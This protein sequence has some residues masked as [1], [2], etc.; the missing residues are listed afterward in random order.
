MYA[1]IIQDK[2][3]GKEEVSRYF[4]TKRA[5]KSWLRWLTKDLHKTAHIMDQVGGIRVP[6]ASKFPGV[7]HIPEI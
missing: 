3:S 2:T 7:V 6:D 1:V 4:Q 5:A